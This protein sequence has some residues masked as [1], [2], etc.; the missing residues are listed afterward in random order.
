M[1]S[2]DFKFPEESWIQLL[3]G[4]GQASTCSKEL[5]AAEGGPPLPKRGLPSAGLTPPLSSAVIP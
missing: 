2:E 4:A 5:I 1:F 3:K